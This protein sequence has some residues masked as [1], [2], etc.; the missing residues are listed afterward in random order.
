MKR[1]G[2]KEE[3]SL[4]M[5]TLVRFAKGGASGCISGALLQPLQ[6]IKTSMQVK[7]KDSGTKINLSFMEACRLINTK[8]GP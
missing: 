6:V 5:Q 8:E 4:G 3:R 2:Q 1:E 7:P